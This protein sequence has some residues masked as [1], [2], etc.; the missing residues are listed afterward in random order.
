VCVR[1]CVRT[2]VCACACV[3]VCMHIGFHVVCTVLNDKACTTVSQALFAFVVFLGSG[4]TCV[5]VCL[6]VCVCAMVAMRGN[7][8]LLGSRLAHA[9][10]YSD[11]QGVQYGVRASG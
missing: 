3:R 7:M 10:V 8:F 11:L 6:C 9:H 1:V 5:C 4:R 2:R